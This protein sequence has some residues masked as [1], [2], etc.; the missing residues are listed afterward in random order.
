MCSGD[1][2]ARG[3]ATGPETPLGKPNGT[4]DENIFVS[5][6]FSENKLHT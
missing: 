3:Q 5:L 4:K 1:A 2:V 6:L